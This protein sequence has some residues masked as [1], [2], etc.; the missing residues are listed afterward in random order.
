MFDLFTQALTTSLSS[1]LPGSS[2]TQSFY[3]YCVFCERCCYFISLLTSS[4]RCCCCC[5]WCCLCRRPRPGGEP[6]SGERLLHPASAPP[7]PAVP[8]HA[9]HQGGP[10]AGQQWPGRAHAGA[11][12]RAAAHQAGTLRLCVS[13]LSVPVACARRRSHGKP[14]AGVNGPVL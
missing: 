6:G 10:G 9:P 8:P 13:I 5:C 14:G 4:I 1:V 7:H 2:S 3:T 11:D 12:L